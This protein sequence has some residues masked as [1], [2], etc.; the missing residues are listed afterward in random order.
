MSSAESQKPA[1]STIAC[2]T[3]GTPLAAQLG[4]HC[5]LCLLGL[6]DESAG[7]D[8][9]A[10]SEGAMSGLQNRRFGDY[11][12]LEEIARGGMGVVYRARQVSL[13]REV[14]L[15]MILAGELAGPD[16]LR[17][18]R[19]EAHA[20]AQ[21]HHPNIVPVHEIGEHELQHYFSMRLVPGGRSIAHWAEGRRGEWKALAEAVAKAARAVAFAHAHG[22]LHRDLKP[23]NILWDDAAGPQVTDFGLAKL[24]DEVDG[25]MTL[26]ARVFGSPNYMAPE[27]AGGKDAVVTTAT[28]VY[29]L[30]AVLYELLS[31]RPPFRGTSALDT[32]RRAV[33]LAPEPLKGVPKDLSTICLK[34]LEK[35]PARRYRSAAALADDLERWLRNE[36]IDARSAGPAERLAK[37]IRRHPAKA[38]LVATAT[39][40]LVVLVVG[41]LFHTRRTNEARRAA[42]VAGRRLAGELRRVEWQ[43]AEDALAA[44]RTLDAMATFARF[45]RETPDD[46]AVAA[47]LRSLLEM[48]AFPLPTLPPLKH[49]QA[50]KLACL[51]ASRQRLFTLT[52]DG[53]LRSWQPTNGHLEKEVQSDLGNRVLRPL[54]GDR[55]LVRSRAGQFRVLSSRSWEAE[56]ELGD[57]EPVHAN[58]GLSASGRWL[59]LVTPRAEIESWDT[60]TG[61]LLA[62]TNIVA[63]APNIAGTVGPDGETLLRGGHEGM[64]LW[65]PA[66]STL[67]ALVEPTQ[68]TRSAHADWNHFRAYA[69][70]GSER[71]PATNLLV[72]LD[73]RTGRRLASQSGERN[74][75]LLEPSP[76]GT[77]LLVSVWGS[78]A[79][80]LHAE[81]MSFA[82]PWFGTAPYEANFSA[83]AAFQVGFRAL[84]DGTGR[85]Y[86]LDSGQPLMEPVQH[87]GAISSHELSPD[88]RILL[89]ASQDGTARLWDVGMRPPDT[90]WNHAGSWVFSMDRS[91][92]GT[93]LVAAINRELR[94]YDLKSGALLFPAPVS[95]DIVHYVRFSP[96][97]RLVGAACFDNSVCVVEA[98][99]GRVLW[100]DKG[101]SARVFR[102]VFSPDGRW[103][104]ASSED[105]SIRIL[106]AL[107]GQPRFPSLRHE[108][109]VTDVAFSPDGRL[110]ASCSVDATARLWDL[111]TGRSLDTRFNHLGTVWTVEFSPDG[112]RL[113]TAST[114]RTAQVWDVRSGSRVG[115]PIRADQGLNGAKFSA[116]ARRV[117]IYTLNGARIHEVETGRPL[118]QLMRHTGRVNM[119]SFS[120]DGRWIGTASDDRTARVW[121]AATGYPV[122]E[123]LG[124]EIRAVSL[125]WEKDGAHFLTSSKDGYILRWKSPEEK[126]APPWLPDLAES[127][128]GKR[129]EPGGGSVAVAVDR[130]DDLRRQAAQT[131]G[132]PDQ[133]WLHWFLVQRLE[134]PDRRPP[135]Q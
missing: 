98:K 63:A 19:R 64:W 122:T 24:L 51:D 17:M 83:D 10:G 117:L 95:A 79:A 65:H 71:G 43:Q 4:G 8:S 50:V 76:D 105:G 20:A 107:S 28:D 11:E 84:H 128:A 109:E 42:E 54:P 34:C 13:N 1:L 35:D 33:E 114:D 118:T 87:A 15:K 73:L 37:W 61:Q 72:S 86:G 36:P 3:C 55:L 66:A 40:G 120:P 135:D 123:P 23:S 9:V 78:G 57:S 7:P 88:G 82:L 31:G 110:L 126:A 106:D 46:T 47:R 94:F 6:A 68:P 29:G 30:G 12:L 132:D 80:V 62:R 81:T 44:G 77:R 38:A 119:A 134:S 25:S 130:L 52:A 45:L 41:Q 70:L 14:A 111:A 67:T 18:F 93:Q 56:L 21:L 5:P 108:G 131:G 59:S 97:G 39:I 125:L 133:R 85:I 32:I 127:L 112:R 91:P 104:A 69:C 58:W 22:V 53:T 2:A 75:T 48:R 92:D 90:T 116:D 89:T 100:R 113:L 101:F 115:P 27:Q 102:A 74:W 16:A 99:T 26:S 121:D 96:D 124:F 103:L 49:G 60:S 129:S